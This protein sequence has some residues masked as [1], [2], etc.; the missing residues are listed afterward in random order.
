M[1]I[2]IRREWVYD[3]D[4]KIIAKI[5]VIVWGVIMEYDFMNHYY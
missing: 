4:I 1:E 5:R 2:I 3:E